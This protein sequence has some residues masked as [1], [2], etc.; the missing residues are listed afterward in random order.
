MTPDSR[1]GAGV[2]CKGGR[3]Y[4]G[5]GEGESEVSQENGRK[6]SPDNKREKIESEDELGSK[7]VSRADGWRETILR[8]K[9]G[10]GRGSGPRLNP[11][12]LT[13]ILVRT[14]ESLSRTKSV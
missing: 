3:G 13:M 6:W 5:Q 1:R 12:Y 14:A 7:P 11:A 8:N 2:G 10:G 9:G 4:G